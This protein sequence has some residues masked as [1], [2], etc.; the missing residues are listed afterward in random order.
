[1]TISTSRGVDHESFIQRE[2]RLWIYKCQADTNA[3]I[4][5][6]LTRDV[7]PT[8]DRRLHRFLADDVPYGRSFVHGN[9]TKETGGALLCRE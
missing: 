5:G 6:M 3:S 1:M 9:A 4:R 2:Y 7:T 8:D